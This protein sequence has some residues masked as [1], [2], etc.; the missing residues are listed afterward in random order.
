VNSRYTAKERERE[1]ERERQIEKERQR[2][3]ERE[4]ER[5]RDFLSP[6]VKERN[7]FL[8]SFRVLPCWLISLFTW[9]IREMGW[10]RERKR[11]EERK[12]ERGCVCA[13]EREV[14]ESSNIHFFWIF[15]AHL[16]IKKRE[17][18]VRERKREKERKREGRK[19]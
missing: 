19:I 9:W 13:R 18:G 8:W 6:N 2:E 11:E 7:V 14:R 15:L 12:I 10:E 17:R 1:R 3:R 4:K 5:E 16:I